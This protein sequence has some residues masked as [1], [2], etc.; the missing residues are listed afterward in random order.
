MN[1]LTNRKILKKLIS[2]DILEQAKLQNVK[3]PEAQV[4]ASDV[5][6]SLDMIIF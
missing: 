1:V 5:K 3:L 2:D 6:K 4:E